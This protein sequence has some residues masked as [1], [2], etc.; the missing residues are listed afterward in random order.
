MQEEGVRKN[1][2]EKGRNRVRKLG[3]GEGE[4]T[5]TGAQEG[6]GGRRRRVSKVGR[7]YGGENAGVQGEEGNRA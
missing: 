7:T 4:R 2:N 6:R 3:V 5:T 1:E